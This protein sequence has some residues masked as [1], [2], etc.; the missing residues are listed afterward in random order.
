MI[1][2]NDFTKDD[3]RPF[4]IELAKNDGY[5][6][7]SLSLDSLLEQVKAFNPKDMT[8]NFYLTIHHLCKENQ[9]FFWSTAHRKDITKWLKKSPKIVECF[10]NGKWVNLFD[11]TWLPNETIKN[12]GKE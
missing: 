4:I 6:N 8:F 5:V 9:D 11:T 12:N 7:P 2:Q 1:L 3:L 10:I